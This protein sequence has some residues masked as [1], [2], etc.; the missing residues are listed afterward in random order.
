MKQI[1]QLLAVAPNGTSK[2]SGSATLAATPVFFWTSCRSVTGLSD[3]CAVVVMASI[4]KQEVFIRHGSFADQ[5]GPMQER[6]HIIQ[7]LSSR[8]HT[9]VTVYCHAG[10][11]SAYLDVA[12]ILKFRIVN[13]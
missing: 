11:E 7:T 2:Q 8:D 6:F 13:S 9:N 5:Q 12:A 1:P 3:A 10:P 4:P